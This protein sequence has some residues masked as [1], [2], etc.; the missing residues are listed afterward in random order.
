MR[1]LSLIA[2]AILLTG[3]SNGQLATIINLDTGENLDTAIPTML[4]VVKSC[5]LTTPSGREIEFKPNDNSDDKFQSLPPTEFVNCRARVANVDTNDEGVWTLTAEYDTGVSQLQSYNLTVNPPQEL[6]TEAPTVP[7]TET[8]SSTEPSTE[9]TIIYFEKII[10]NSSIGDSHDVSIDGNIFYND[11]ICQIITPSGQQYDLKELNSSY[12]EVIPQDDESCYVTIKVISEEVVGNWTLISDGYLYSERVQRRLPFTI[13]VEEAVDASAS[14]ITV[15]EGNNMYVRL[16]NAIENYDTCRLLAPNGIEYNEYEKDNRY[17]EQ[18][19]FIVRNIQTTDSGN[20]SILYGNRVIYRA[21][22]SVTVNAATPGGTSNLVWTRDRPVTEFFG[23]ENAVY[24]KVVGPDGLVYYDGFGMCQI[25]IERV[26]LDH[27]GIWTLSVGLPGRVLTENSQFIV[28]VVEAE[29]KPAVVTQVTANK[30]TVSLTC[31]VSSPHPI[32]SCKFRHPS[33]RILMANEG[34]GE[35]RFSYHGAAVSYQSDVH[36]HDCGLLITNPLVEDLGIWRCAIETDGDTF[37]GFLKVLCPWALRDPEVAAAV[38]TEPVLTASRNTVTSLAGDSVSMSCS[39]QSAIRYCYFRARNGTVF[40]VGPAHSHD[41]ANYIGSGFDAGECGIRFPT[42]AVSDTGSWS[43]HVGFLTEPEQRAQINV[44]IQDPMVA[45]QRVEHGNL[46]IEAQVYDNRSLEYCRFVRI[47]GSGFTS[48]ENIQNNYGDIS[49]LSQ[50]KCGLFIEH[51]S[52][53]D[54]HP[55][56]V[57]AKIMGQNEEISRVTPIT[58][59]RPIPETA[60]SHVPVI[61]VLVMTLGITLLLLSALLVN[62]RS[63]EWTYARASSI[64]NSFTRKTVEQQNTT[65]KTTAMAA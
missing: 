45:D 65:E 61:W 23:A 55:W 51:P 4:N 29:L 3:S 49:V 25:L 59:A 54:H 10:F 28:R 32:N 36:T 31:S 40:N 30:P 53:L 26:S 1:S 5:Y 41:Q 60:F 17:L 57:V 12:V 14:E 11:P 21:T 33:G 44:T 7:S 16:K 56:T 35:D 8:P 18:C 39:V 46:I 15:V 42:L 37:Y 48:L 52:I 34:V 50:G 43:C 63:R 20:W 38:V 13:Y 19:G 2:L 9:E 58:L 47:D 24:C 22:I 62:K 6:S 27:E 64:R